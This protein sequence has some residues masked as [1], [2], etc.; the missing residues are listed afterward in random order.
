M[1]F[2]WV[3]RSTLQTVAAA[4]LA[5]EDRNRQLCQQV[6]DLHVQLAAALRDSAAAREQICNWIGQY[7]FGHAVFGPLAL[8]PEAPPADPEPMPRRLHGREIVARAERELHEAMAAHE[9]S[10]Q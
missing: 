5:A 3:R 4:R 7:T 10:L 1:T 6:E 8:P 9:E 2:P